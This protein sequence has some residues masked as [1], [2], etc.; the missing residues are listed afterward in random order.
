MVLVKRVAERNAHLTA[1]G[2]LDRLFEKVRETFVSSL[3]PSTLL[4]HVKLS[5]KTLRGKFGSLERDRRSTNKINTAASGIS[6]EIIDLYQLLDDLIS[7]K[8]RKEEK[9][10]E[11]RDE[12]N[13]RDARLVEYGKKT[14]GYS[15]I[16]D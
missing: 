12:A 11:N 8:D 6:E 13:G 4:T 7:E 3:S 9:R 15:C 10:S 5:V 1:H 16:Q 2:Q 14:E